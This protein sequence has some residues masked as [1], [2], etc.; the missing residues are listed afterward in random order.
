MQTV[1]LNEKQTKT[2]KD[3]INAGTAPYNTFDGR[4]IRAL[5]GRELVKV[6]ENR[7]GRFVTATTKGR[8]VVN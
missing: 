7:K 1:T 8:K 2:L 5:S 4:A 3:I 6:K